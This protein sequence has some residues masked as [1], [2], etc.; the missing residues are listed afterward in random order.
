VAI[1]MGDVVGRGIPAAALVGKL[2]N[3]LRV[4]A[5]DGHAPGD[6]V[7]RVNRFIDDPTTTP[8]ATLL[9]GTYDRDSGALE[10]VNAGH[11]PPVVRGP[12]G[13]VEI[14]AIPPSPPLGATPHTRYEAFSAKL[15]PGSTLLLYTD[16]LVERRNAPISAGMDAVRR[17]LAAE[18]SAD[19]ACDRVLSALLPDR[20]ATDDVA[21]LALHVLARVEAQLSL[22]RPA[23]P[24]S[25]AGIRQELRH[26]LARHGV[27]R[28]TIDRVL[29]T[30][31]EACSNA[32][33]HAYGPGDAWFELDA[34]IGD[35]ALTVTVRDRGRWR[36]PRG[37]NRGRG[38]QLIHA[39]ADGVDVRPEPTGTSVTLRHSLAAGKSP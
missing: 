38:L 13:R 17:A 35:G 6:V 28:G 20:A 21:L 19:A 32:V 36:D 8:M 14:L 15:A 11:P 5:L 39:V 3:A 37:S 2:R 1:V 27:D 30:S 18:G 9:Y 7:E 25:L 23:R 12:D 26:W 34:A 29:L 31:G 4:Y 22:R 10:M 16:G 33:E 24:D